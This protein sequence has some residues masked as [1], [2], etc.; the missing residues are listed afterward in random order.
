MDA[1]QLININSLK[2]SLG[3]KGGLYWTF[4]NTEEFSTL[5]RVHLSRLAQKWSS[6]LP[7]PASSLQQNTEQSDFEDNSDDYGIL[8]YQEIF[9][10]SMSIVTES[11]ESIAS[12]TIRIGEQFTQRSDEINQFNLSNDNNDKA[13]VRKLIKKS[14]HDLDSFSEILEQKLSIASKA[15]S[16]ALEALSKSISL[17]VSDLD[18]DDDPSF[19]IDAIANMRSAAADSRTNISEFKE[20][21]DSLPRMTIELNKSKRRAS[22]A[23]NSMLE[24][25]ETT[26]QSTD[27][28]L[29]TLRSLKEKFIP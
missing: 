6:G 9:E 1:H 18:I 7:A 21:I 17:Q 14:S 25:I 8:D 20:S 23:L 15:R 5:V 10:S 27:E 26:L 19:L 29:K 13:S 3:E 2:S 28:I 4:E 11:F 24:E 22:N 16:E 12:A